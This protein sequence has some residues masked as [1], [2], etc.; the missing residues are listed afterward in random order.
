ME[1]WDHILQTLK[2][3]GESEFIVSADNIKEC[4]KSWKG[5]ANQFEPRLLCYQTSTTTRP[6]AFKKNGLYILPIKNG[7]YL[8]TKQNIYM[9]LDYSG[10]QT[11]VIKRDNSSVILGIGN[12]ETS[13]IDNM[14]YSGVFEREE[15][16]GEP[17]THGPLLN[18]RHRI[19]MDMK[20]GGKDI[21]ISG[22]QYETD[23][24]YESK[25]KI[26]IIEG[27]SCTKEIDSFNIRQLYFP[28]REATRLAKNTKEI[29]CVFVHEL[30]GKIH[31]W[32]Y[33]FENVEMMDSIK[34]V[35]HYVYTFSS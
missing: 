6:T 2:F 24:C 23:S 31:V 30:K 26:L 15:I 25:N 1:P 9:P 29:V 21:N 18:G 7:T 11:F 10:G 16:L 5:A 12:S 3:N 32:K 8:L 34:V 14:R 35:G 13:L 22:V 19:N 27:K 33:T 20:L 28:F 4:G 17:I